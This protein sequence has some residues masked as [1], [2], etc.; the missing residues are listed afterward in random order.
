MVVIIF[1]EFSY[2]ELLDEGF[3]S[4]VIIEEFVEWVYF[5]E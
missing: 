3:F 2:L 1:L 5:F 4:V